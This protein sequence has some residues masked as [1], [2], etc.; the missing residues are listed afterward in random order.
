MDLC[1]NNCSIYVGAPNESSINYYSGAVYRFLN[2][3]RIYGTILGSVQNPTVT[4]GDSIRINNFEVTFPTNTTLS[5]VVSR[6]NTANI[7]GITA[8]SVNGYLQIDSVSQISTNKL[9]ILPGVGNA[10]SELGLDVYIETQKIE[11]PTNHAYDYF[12][13]TVRINNHS[14]ILVVGSSQAI[15]TQATTFDVATGYP[16]TFDGGSTTFHDET[17]SGAVWILNYLPDSRNSILYPGTFAYVQQLTMNSMSNV[18][19]LPYTN[20]GQAF[21]IMDTELLVSVPLDNSRTTGGGAVYQFNNADNLLGW[22]VYRSEEAKV[23]ISSILKGYL[24]SVSNQTIIDSLDY[25]DPAKGKIL[26]VAEQ[27]ISYRTD[28]DPATYNNATNDTVASS[29]TFHWNDSQVGQVWWDLSTMKYIDYEQG[30]IK[31]RTNNWG[32]VFPGSSID[33]YEW[34]ESLYPPSQYVANGGSGTPKHE[35]NSAYATKVYVD[36]ATNVSTIL[37]YFWVKNKNTVTVNQFGR[38]IPTTTI[39][40]YIRDPKNSGIKFFA[41]VRDDSISLYNVVGILTG[42]DVVYHLDYATKLN[43]NIIHSEYAL[44]SEGDTTADVIPQNIYN[45]LLDSLSGTDTFGN[46]VPDVRLPVQ[47][48]YGIDIRPRQSMFIDNKMAIEQM[49]DFVNSVFAKN[50]ITQGYDLSGLTNSE[51]YP[52]GAPTT[53]AWT[54]NTFYTKDQIISYQYTSYIALNNFTSGST[55]TQGLD[56]V[57]YFYY[58]LIVASIEQLGYINVS[59]ISPGYKVLV[60]EDTTVDGLWTI[61]TLQSDLTWLLSKVESYKTSN[62]WSFVDWYAPGFDNTVRPN[63]TI[64]TIADIVNLPLQN[65]DIVKVLNNGQGQWTL[66]QV[67]PNI[68]TTIGIQNGT[69]ELSKSLYTGYGFDVENFDSDRFDQS[70]SIEI[71]KILDALRNQ[72]FINQLSPEFVSLF[73]VFV[74]YVLDEQKYIDWAFKTSF[75]DVVQKVAG[76]DQPQLYN[77]DNQNY[78]RQYIEEVKPYHTTIK[79]YIID[80]EGKDN[81]NGYVTDFDVPAYW[82]PVLQMYRSP[83]GEFAEDIRA[84]QQPQYRDWLLNYTYVIDSIDIVDGGSGYTTAPAVTITGSTIGNDAVARAYVANGVV[85]RIDVLYSGTNYVTQPVITFDGGSTTP[86]KAYARLTNGKIRSLKTTLVYDRITFGSGVAEWTSNTTYD[87]GSLLAYNGTAYVVNTTF[88]SGNSF[89]GSNLTVYPAYKLSSANDRIQSYYSPET[90]LPGKSFDLLQPGISYPGVT[91]EGLQFTESRTLDANIE[92]YFADTE[93]GTRPEDIVI[94]GGGY[95]DPYSSHAPEELI[96]GR[97]FDTL[98]M[99]VTT[100]ATDCTSGDYTSWVANDAFYVSDILILDGGEGYSDLDV[101]ITIS[102]G[103]AVTDATIGN[104]VLDA[105]G[106]IISAEVSAEGIGYTSF[107]NVVIT[108]G[109][110]STATASVRLSPTNAPSSVEPYSTFSYRI[111]KTLNSLY[112][113]PMDASGDSNVTYSFYRIDPAATTTLSSNLGL[114]D[115]EISVIDASVLFDPQ[116]EN[117]IP[118]VIYINGERITYYQRFLANSTLG[119]IRRGTG[120]TGATEHLVGSSVV[121]ASPLQVVPQS[122]PI[123]YSFLVNT[124]V[125]TTSANTTPNAIGTYTFLT[126]NIYVRSNL[127]LSPGL[128]SQEIVAEYVGNVSVNPITTET[129]N[130]FITDGSDYPTPADGM[131]LYNSTTI[132]A[133]FVKS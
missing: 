21:D 22:D 130:V 1:P 117:N 70:P 126:G 97:T 118:G 47:S 7:P 17:P 50:I 86:A 106:T 43:S 28:Y 67:F 114:T 51:P 121:D 8:S 19:M 24:Y 48:R 38:Q 109:N 14:N 2:Q 49:V 124:T 60:Q 100:F 123:G 42:T 37:Y 12:G 59:T 5:Y 34:V 84:L 66:L 3:G 98:N 11:N 65:S 30:S 75:I 110:A 72:L 105:N 113:D 73:F 40:E 4:L 128:G 92:S 29:K 57:E 55:F 63:Y 80:Y 23:D 88:T 62:Y 69:I 64:A 95:V 90:G 85:T 127:W 91:V 46:P 25:I 120:G 87:Q 44:I 115:T 104:I 103:G 52:P 131:G 99:T 33:V 45:K 27:E 83:S 10:I 61:Y 56:L 6:I 79:E 9:T 94:D 54:P 16:T 101:A 20:F 39:A 74:Y 58:D 35:D 111:V 18:D 77:R 15:T 13:E 119:Q 81:F 108:G 116:P 31:Y 82:D 68:V 41:T 112:I 53:V 76:L 78:Y 36:P 26:G 129:G 133:V 32:R 102:G 125:Q 107:P 93:L 132:Q 71:R 122:A 96:P 89:V